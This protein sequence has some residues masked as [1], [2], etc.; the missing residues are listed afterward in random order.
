[1]ETSGGRENKT[2]GLKEGGS[3]CMRV[4]KPLALARAP[5]LCLQNKYKIFVFPPADH[6]LHGSAKFGDK[7]YCVQH[8]IRGEI[9]LSHTFRWKKKKPASSQ[10]ESPLQLCHS[11]GQG[12][13]LCLQASA[14]PPHH[15]LGFLPSFLLAAFP[16]QRL[17]EDDTASAF[18]C[19]FSK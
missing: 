11:E 8:L 14:F 5:W 3:G 13:A 1:M 15:L 12:Q 7:G 9:C 10:K 16:K 4:P 17:P 19:P 18:S 6:A 2:T